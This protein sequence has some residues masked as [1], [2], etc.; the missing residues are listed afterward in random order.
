MS[1]PDISPALQK[2]LEIMCSP[3]VPV[4]RSLLAAKAII[5]YEAPEEVKDLTYRF[6]MGVAEGSDVGLQ[7]K[8]LELLRKVEAKRVSPG[9]TRGADPMDGVG[10]RLEEARLRA[11]QKRKVMN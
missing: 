7:L 8:A 2:L 3:D 5:E 6:L 10:K 4:A 11:E 1:N 9:T